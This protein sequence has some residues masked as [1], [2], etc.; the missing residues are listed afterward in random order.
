MVSIEGRTTPLA[1]VG[2]GRRLD[3]R[4][5]RMRD[6]GRLGSWFLL[7]GLGLGLKISGDAGNLGVMQVNSVLD[8][9]RFVNDG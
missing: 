1:H 6:S 8:C 9:Y 2:A 3:V 5:V 4:Y 7:S